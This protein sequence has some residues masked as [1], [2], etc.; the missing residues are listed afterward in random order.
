MALT[1][2]LRRILL[3]L[4]LVAVTAVFL[5]FGFPSEELR[6]HAAYRLSAA[7]PGLG[8]SVSGLRPSLPAGVTLLGVRIAYGDHPLAVLDRLR[9]QP[10]LMSILQPK[11]VYSFEGALGCGEHH[12]SCGAGFLRG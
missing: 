6:T 11:T 9:V 2:G 4:Y 1:A 8:I 10:E 5:Y 3:A 7:L 12:R